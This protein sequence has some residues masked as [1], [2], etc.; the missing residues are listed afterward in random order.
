MNVTC[1]FAT[2]SAHMYL[3][4]THYYIVTWKE[5]NCSFSIFIFA[6]FMLVLNMQCHFT[7][8]LI[9]SQPF[10]QNFKIEYQRLS[11]THFFRD[12]PSTFS[13]ET[14]MLEIVSSQCS[15]HTIIL[16]LQLCNIQQN[17]LFIMYTQ[18]KKN[19]KL[20]W[21]NQYIYQNFWT[22][23]HTQP[24]WKIWLIT[25]TIVIHPCKPEGP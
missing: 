22:G 18:S 7:M 16:T 24:F 10:T 17:T 23:W 6:T 11:C 21:C 9:L 1:V 3:Q 5:Q 25:L 20:L 8:P 19:Y 14:M 13:I 2:W 12:I 4:S 15:I